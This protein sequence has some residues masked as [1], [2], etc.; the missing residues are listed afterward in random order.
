MVPLIAVALSAFLLWAAF[1][2]LDLGPLA[3]VAVAPFL[4]A[5]R[6]V[7]RGTQAMFLGFAFGAT[8]FGSL[9]FWILQLGTVAWLPFTIFMGAITSVY[10][11]SIWAFRLFPA[12]RWWLIA[13]GGW[14]VME[15][16]RGHFPFGGFPWGDVGYAA[17]RVPGGLGSVQWIGPF[18]WS[19]L[20]VGFSAGLALLV[21]S[22]QNWRFAV[23][24]GV[25]ILLIAIA[26]GLFPPVADGEV[27][28][29][30]IVQGGTP[31][32]QVHCQNEN[33]RIYESHLSLTET[34]P[35]GFVD[36]VVWAE[37]STGPPYEPDGNDAVRAQIIEQATRIGAH[38][39]VSGTRAGT[40]PG[41]FVNVN[42]FY[43]PDG[44]KIGEYVKRHPVPFGEFV[45]MRGLLDFIPQL[46]QVPNDMVRGREP[47]VFPFG[48][49]VLGSVISFEGAFAR[50]VRSMAAAGSTIM[51]VATNESSFGDSPASDQLI[52]L[53]RVNAAAIG[54]DLVHAAITGRSAFIDAD[55]TVQPPTQL[56]QE[57]VHYGRLQMRTAGPTLYTRFGD[58]VMLIA[59]AGLA[60]ALA[61]PGEVG[62]DVVGRRRQDR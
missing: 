45:P 47:V 6:Q 59:L 1:P 55:G 42:A 49:G 38:F 10:A 3:L 53:V 36:L 41:T 31:C 23:D 25:V 24:T 60:L 14:L 22:R 18:G 7:E 26:G 2:P 56:F 62:F 29:V 28:Q 33:Q 21:E 43:S 16:L 17:V 57:T 19:L 32:P 40:E 54:Q 37:N 12:W 44:V 8:F 46:E 11:V 13:V 58:W 15:W 5:I 51:V 20:A 52:G 34:I 39:L 4:W 61:L 30:G 27:V 50:H 48:D 35:D 9:L